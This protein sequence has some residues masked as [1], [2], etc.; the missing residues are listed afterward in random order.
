MKIHRFRSLKTIKLFFS[1]I[2]LQH[3]EAQ[4]MLYDFVPEKDMTFHLAE[5]ND[6]YQHQ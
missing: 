5:P 1:N 6:D 3:K 4:T 2:Q